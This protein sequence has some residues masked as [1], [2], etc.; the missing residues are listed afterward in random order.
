MD[1]NDV[2]STMMQECID[3]M[4]EIGIP[5]AK[6]SINSIDFKKLNRINAGCYYEC[7]DGN[8]V[9]DIV[10]HNGVV[11]YIDDDVVL[12]NVRNSIYHELLHTCPNCSWHN[13]EFV[14]WSKICNE[15]L[16]T[17]TTSC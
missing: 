12:N 10:I 2:L 3:K 4:L 6:D 8:M 9:Y 1:V 16:G 15:K 11:R 17:H 7:V 14:K 13:D 5:V